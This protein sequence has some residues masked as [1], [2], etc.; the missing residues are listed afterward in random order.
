MQVRSLVE[1]GSELGCTSADTHFSKP[2]ACSYSASMSVVGAFAAPEAKDRLSC[3]WRLRSWVLSAAG[4]VVC[5]SVTPK[6]LKAGP[7]PTLSLGATEQ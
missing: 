7:T 6:P 1:A 3:S 2:V 4:K 5:S